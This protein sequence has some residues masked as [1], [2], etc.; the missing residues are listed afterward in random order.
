MHRLDL[1]QPDDFHLHLRDGAQLAAVL[2]DTVRRFARA[3]VMPNLDP[4]VTTVAL[5]A[6]YRRRILA[7]LPPGA[8][9][10]PLMT[11]YL[12]DDTRPEEIR[13]ARDSGFIHGVK[14]Y[15]AGATTHSD[16]G[17]SAVTRVTAVLEAMQKCGMR[18]QVHGEV[19]D[20]D[21]DVF[22][23]ETVFI[24]NVLA[25]LVA[26]FP[27]LQVVF[28]HVTTRAAVQ[29]VEGAGATVAATITPQHLLFNR[30]ALFRGGLR[31]HYYCLPVLKA[32]QDRAALLHA[33]TSGHARFFLGTDSA[34]HARSAKERDCGCAGCYSAP[35][36][37]ELYAQAF[38][39]AGALPKLEAFGSVH[40]AAF[41][42]LPR[43]TRR[44]SLERRDWRIPEELPYGG[45]MVVPLAA[46]ETCRWT[47][48]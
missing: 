47:L 2:P 44:V 36:A 33:A 12:T 23:R 20:P 48:N 17:V 6:A 11:L 3:V 43:N 46:G 37:L 26:E 27:E 41:Y 8:V 15:P 1:I 18:L 28:E 19:T 4:P 39:E 13:A 31:P 45:E 9:F 10:E 24:D 38:E 29:F 16:R 35:A 40:G 7:A 22:D 34:P 42:G 30:N 14:L 5:A 25:P 21:V 32:E